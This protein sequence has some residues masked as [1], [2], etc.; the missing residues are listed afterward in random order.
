MQRALTNMKTKLKG[1]QKGHT[2]LKRKSDA[3]TV[4]FR[5]ILQKISDAKMKMGKVMQ[6][7]SFSL[8]EVYYVAGD[9]G[10]KRCVIC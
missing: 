4:R 8:A 6:N 10:Y 2:L 3:L 9:I 1:A 5:A 7:A